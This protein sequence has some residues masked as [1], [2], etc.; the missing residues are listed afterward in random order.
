MYVSVS[1]RVPVKNTYMALLELVLQNMKKSFDEYT[2]ADTFEM[3]K[4]AVL[5]Y[6]SNKLKAG[7]RATAS[8]V[9]W[10]TFSNTR[11]PVDEKIKVAQA[12]TYNDVKDFIP[13][14]LSSISMEGFIYGSINEADAT[15]VY[16][17]VEQTLRGTTGGTT[18]ASVL[19][20]AQ[21][22][23]SEIRVLPADAGPW[24]K[25][26][27][28]SARSN[29]TILMIDGG[30]LPCDEAMALPVLY[31]V[32]GNRFFRELRT[33]QQTGYVASTYATTIA[34]RSV[35]LMLVESSW[36][37][38]GDLLKRF[39]Q[40]NADVL[41]G[42][43]DGTV[44][45]QAKL[46]SIKGAMLAS[47]EKPIQNTGGMAGILEGIIK[48]Y[49]GDFDAEKKKQKILE[50]LTR[51]KIVKVANKVLGPQNKRKFAVLYAPSGVSADAVKALMPAEY[52][53]FVNNT[54]SFK[55]KPKYK[56]DVCVTTPCPAANTT[57]TP[58][59]QAAAANTT[60]EGCEEQ[61]GETAASGAAEVV[62]LNDDVTGS[63]MLSLM[64]I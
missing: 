44:M 36:A 14:L 34:R 2:S 32:V 31:K 56:C 33:K 22:F 63:S 5:R 37:G 1:G 42:V 10:N 50:D 6:Y 21:E 7:A 43:N 30:H 24:F 49:D 57:V 9:L 40:F 60:L 51:D 54:G 62:A 16:R 23:V 3:I 38:A 58:C 35:V 61:L 47:F 52:K 46:D 41:K 39:E 29:S 19:P 8:R 59:Q 25:S 26:V 13:E 55:P 18:P 4:K 45:P 28:G 11:L 15:E 12:T 20:E 64:D 53:L 27:S 48:D 17:K